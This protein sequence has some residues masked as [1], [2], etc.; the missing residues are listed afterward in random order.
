VVL[1]PCAV[2]LDRWASAGAFDISFYVVQGVELFA[3]AINLSLM[4]MNMRDGLR[5]SGAVLPQRQ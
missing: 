5:M 1:I 3:G 2:F 4:G